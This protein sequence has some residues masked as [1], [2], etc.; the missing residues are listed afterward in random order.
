MSIPTAL[1]PLPEERE[2][3]TWS[4]VTINLDRIIEDAHNPR[5]DMGEHDGSF[6]ALVQ[7]IRERGMLLPPLVRP[8]SG[9]ADCQYHIIAGHRR[10]AAARAL[11][12]EAVRCT[13]MEDCEGKPGDYND[14]ERLIDTL[15]ENTQRKDLN[16]IEVAEAIVRLEKLGKTQEEIGRW[17]G[18][19]QSW[20]SK[21]ARL[22]TLPGG[23]LTLLRDGGLT[24]SHGEELLPLLGESFLPGEIEKLAHQASEQNLT[25]SGLRN[26]VR[27]KIER[28]RPQ[29]KVLTFGEQTTLGDYAASNTPESAPEEDEFDARIARTLAATKGLDKDPKPALKDTNGL[30]RKESDQQ[31]AEAMAP[32]P[33]VVPLSER[34]DPETASD[35]PARAILGDWLNEIG[36][37][38]IEAAGRLYSI[39][40]PRG[41]VHKPGMWLRLEPETAQKLMEL[42]D[43][44]R[45][46]HGEGLLIEQKLADVVR[47]FHQAK[48]EMRAE[49][50]ASKQAREASFPVFEE[51]APAT[52]PPTP[53]EFGEAQRQKELADQ[54]AAAERKAQRQKK[55][56]EA[57]AA[58]AKTKTS[59][60]VTYCY[61]QNGEWQ[62]G[63]QCEGGEEGV[64]A[65]FWNL[66][67]AREFA[68]AESS[69]NSRFLIRVNVHT[70]RLD[71]QYD[72]HEQRGD[73]WYFRGAVVP[74]GVSDSIPDEAHLVKVGCNLDELSKEND[75]EF[76]SA[77]APGWESAAEIAERERE[78]QVE[79]A[80]RIAK[81]DVGLFGT[82]APQGIAEGL[83]EFA[84][85]LV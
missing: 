52:K 48:L 9:R 8:V 77:L 41:D 17:V 45:E 33:D 76:A 36:L 69:R 65:I 78:E 70:E 79:R 49:A 39:T 2:V 55:H 16:C 26:V 30:T 51:P 67:A 50:E 40:G 38:W 27:E 80:R 6:A 44:H 29:T 74:G 25:V 3:T 56:A 73:L 24:Q 28:T 43:W 5:R 34:P 68:Q 46:E 23:V 14:T 32:D 84:G 66:A 42:C 20:V 83:D 63:G 35:K 85:A 57:L 71:R 18:R 81:A 10:I 21:C 31:F 53:A 19:G 72:R 13:P 7:S 12:W 60:D 75:R 61:P 59:F 64:P 22:V 37:T 82:P 11:G 47:S 58:K 54:Q 62:G 1:F 15:V 4:S